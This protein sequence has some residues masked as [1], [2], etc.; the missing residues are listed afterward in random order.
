[1]C[2]LPVWKSARS[3]GSQNKDRFGRD[4]NGTEIHARGK[5]QRDLGHDR[6]GQ[7]RAGIFAPEKLER[8]RKTDL[9]DTIV[10]Q[11]YIFSTRRFDGRWSH[12]VIIDGLEVNLPHKVFQALTRQVESIIKEERSERDKTQAEKRRAEMSA[13]AA[14]DQEE[15]EYLENGPEFL[16]LREGG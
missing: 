7:Y 13:L 9:A 12:K 2:G 3:P 15:A 8:H 4:K 10:E 14:A 11:D 16:R 1:M 5:A 6:Y